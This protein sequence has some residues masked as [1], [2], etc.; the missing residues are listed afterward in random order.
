M[1]NVVLHP[2]PQELNWYMPLEAGVK[3]YQKLS[4]ACDTTP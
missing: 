4:P 2:A 1:Y 3:E